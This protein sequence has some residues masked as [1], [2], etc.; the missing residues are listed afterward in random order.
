MWI[1]VT[2]IISCWGACTGR[3]E[4]QGAEFATERECKLAVIYY[5]KL[6]STAHCEKEPTNET[7]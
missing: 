5:Q 4:I 2:V 1:I 7:K 6:D 3:Q